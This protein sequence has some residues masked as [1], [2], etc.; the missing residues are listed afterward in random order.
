MKALDVFKMSLKWLKEHLFDLLK[1]RGQDIDESD[2][3]WVLT[4]PAIWNDAAKQFMRLAGEAV[5]F[6]CFISY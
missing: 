5:R 6:T 1:T 3:Q 4:V 2:I